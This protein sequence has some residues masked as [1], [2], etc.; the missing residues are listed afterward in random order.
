MGEV[1]VVVKVAWWD[2]DVSVMDDGEIIGEGKTHNMSA[3]YHH[4]QAHPTQRKQG[5]TRA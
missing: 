5:I 3:S 4:K 2:V 1:D